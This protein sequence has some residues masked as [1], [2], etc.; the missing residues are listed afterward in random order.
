MMPKRKSKKFMV[1]KYAA[2]NKVTLAQLCNEFVAETQKAKS[3]FYRHVRGD[4]RVHGAD[5][6]LCRRLGITL[7]DLYDRHNI[8]IRR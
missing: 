6:W 8:R 3:S 7:G 1:A 4:I 5:G 2:I